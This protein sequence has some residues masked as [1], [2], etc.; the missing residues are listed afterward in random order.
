MKLP[1]AHNLEPDAATSAVPTNARTQALALIKQHAARG[2]SPR[3]IAE[4]LIRQGIA[5]AH[6]KSRW[7]Y[8]SVVYLAKANGIAL[9]GYARPASC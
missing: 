8:S 7:D 9:K 2:D 4:A 3:Y 5:T 1:I 6:G